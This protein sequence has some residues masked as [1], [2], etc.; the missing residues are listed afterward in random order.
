MQYVQIL[1]CNS[2]LGNCCND[3]GLI[4]IIDITRKIFDLIQLIVPILL[5]TMITVQLIKMIVNP[6]DKKDT[7][8]LVNKIIA[9]FV[10]FFLP[11]IADVIVGLMP[12]EFTISSCWENA[13]IS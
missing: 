6:D 3:Y 1:E 7:K 8:K 2:T 11:T 10:C 5:I 4:T 9:T 12:N 13:K